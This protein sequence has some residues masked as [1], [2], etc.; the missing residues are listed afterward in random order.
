MIAPRGAIVTFALII[1]C[2]LAYLVYGPAHAGR[3]ASVMG[4]FGRVF[5][6][7]DLKH[8]AFNM[9][10]LLF[11]GSRTEDVLGWY[12]TLVLVLVCIVVGTLTQ[13]A[14]VDTQFAGVSGPVYG[15]VAFAVIVDRP[16]RMQLLNAAIIAV[17]LL[18]EVLYLSDTVAIYPH[19]TSATIGAAYAM[20]G[21]LFGSKGPT[22]KPMQMT[23]IA[24]V[25]GIIHQTDDDDAAEAEAEFLE[26]GGLEGMFVLMDRGEVMGCIGYSPDDHSPEIAWLSWTYLDAAYAGQGYGSQMMNDMLGKLNAFGVRK[27][28]IATSDYEEFGKKIYAA[29]HKMYEDFGAEV[30]MTVPDYHTVGEAKI[31][32]GLNNPEFQIGDPPAPSENEG[33]AISGSAKEPE[34][35]NVRGLT[36]SEVPVGV[37]G[38]DHAI[39]KA[40]NKGARMVVLSLPSDL[41]DANSA[42]LES[43]G[44]TKSGKLTDY[45][46]SGLHQDWWICS[47][48]H[49]NT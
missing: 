35:D 33:I 14:L 30:E 7:G 38:L 19:I 37:A 34:T 43:H 8:F 24:K 9:V 1:I 41:S 48:L 26:P 36:W 4:A 21:N 13:I 15:M 6:H 45:Y 49:N 23:H 20:F 31:V 32:Y 17:V 27:I 2:T 40:R 16:R 12:R 46:N 47:V 18:S 28:F 22:L 25:V 10:L 39:E 44:F 11:A 42:A 3:D 29:A 5:L